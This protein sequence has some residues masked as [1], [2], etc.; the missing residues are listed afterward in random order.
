MNKRI[1]AR[2]F[3]KMR[4]RILVIALTLFTFA[5]AKAQ[6]TTKNLGPLGPGSGTNEQTAPEK[7]T[8]LQ[9]NK[10]DITM[11]QVI[12]S[13]NDTTY[14]DTTLTIR[15]DYIYNY[16]RKDNFG[17]LQFAN[18]GQTYNTLDFSLTR[19]NALPLMGFAGKHFFYKEAE[20]INYYSVAT[21]LTELYYKTVMEQGHSLDAFLTLNTSKRLNFSIAYKGVRSQ[22]A[23]VNQLSSSGNFRFTSS[24]VTKNGRYSLRAH[25]TAQDLLNQENGG[26]QNIADFESGDAAFTDRIRLDVFLNDAQTMLRGNRYYLNHHLILAGKSDKT[27]LQITHE[28]LYEHKFQEYSQLTINERFGSSYVPSNV[29]DKVRYNTMRN[30]VGVRFGNDKIGRIQPY[31]AFQNYNYFYRSV[32]VNDNDLIPSSRGLEVGLIGG[33]YTLDREKIRFSA[34]YFEGITEKVSQLKAALTFTPN[35]RITVNASLENLSQIPDFQYNLFQS[36]FVAYNWSNDFVNQKINRL[37]FAADTPWVV[38][39][40]QYNLINDFLYFSNDGQDGVLITTP[41]QY[42]PLISHLAVKVSREFTFGKFALDNTLLFQQVTQQDDI[43]NVPDLVMRNSFYFSDTVFKKALFFQVGVTANYFTSYFANNYNPVLGSF[44]VQN[45]RKIGNFPLLDFFV[46]AKIKQ[47]RIYLKAEHFNSAM[48]GYN[49][50]SAPD[51]PYRD[52][53]I[54]FGLVWNFFQ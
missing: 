31:T 10:A 33:N 48:T 17:L 11:Y 19:Q 29:R 50:Y 5:S 20:D 9:K 23:Y 15:K 49:F 52:F 22:G 2:S 13:K 32:I 3:F 38:A 35:D 42:A 39:S 45:E 53:T 30:Q 43:L 6:R 14:I 1:F 26:I 12:S 28:F 54:R 25:I 44:Y 46:N 36:S 37:S 21:P 4:V 16:L 8:S 34:D 27:N 7:S 41:K 24:Y 47:T 18:E 51:Y 40:L